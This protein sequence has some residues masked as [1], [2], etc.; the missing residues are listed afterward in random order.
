MQCL[1][2]PQEV[3]KFEKAFKDPEFIKLFSD[4]VNEIKDPK[5]RGGHCRTPSAAAC[6]RSEV[7]ASR[8]CSA[9]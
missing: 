6:D 5:V 7:G 4:Y 9:S 8:G 1:L 2:S 3:N